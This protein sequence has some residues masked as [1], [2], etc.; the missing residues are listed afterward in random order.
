MLVDTGC[1]AHT[2]F[3]LRIVI[4]TLARRV[5]RAMD[6]HIVF[7]HVHVHIHTVVTDVLIVDFTTT[8]RK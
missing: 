5:R 8:I 1:V 2:W 6:G 4:S 7:D 3:E